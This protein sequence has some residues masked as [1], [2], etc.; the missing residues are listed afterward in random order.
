MMHWRVQS[1]GYPLLHQ[2]VKYVI[3]PTCQKGM[4]ISTLAL[5]CDTP[6]PA[7]ATGF[8]MTKEEKNLFSKAMSL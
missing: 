8:S 1:E 4:I 6:T 3:M 7:A 5:L 2:T